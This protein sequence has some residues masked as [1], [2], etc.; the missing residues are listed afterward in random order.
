VAE[1]RALIIANDLYKHEGLRRLVAPTHD[2]EALERVLAHPQVG[3]FDVTV[4]RNRQSHEILLEIENFFNDRKPDDLLVLHFSGHGLKSPAGELYL[5]TSDTIP[6]RLNA[7]AVPAHFINRQ[8]AES[9][10]RRIVVFLDCCYG[11]AFDRGTLARSDDTVNVTDAFPASDESRLRAG[12]GR[13]RIVITASSAT[14][15]AFEDGHLADPGIRTPSVFTSALVQGLETGEADLGGDSLVDIDE[16]Y[17]YVHARVTAA[18]NRQTPGRSV[19]RQEG[20]VVIAWT[21]PARR[22]EA[23]EI[24][25]ELA[26]QSRDDSREV[27]LVAVRNLRRILLDEDRAYAVGALDVLRRL[28]TDDSGSVSTAAA[29]AIEEAQ[30]KAVPAQVDLGLLDPDGS[31]RTTI[32]RLVGSP[33]ARVFQATSTTRWLRVEQ[34]END[35]DDSVRITV[36]NEALPA[37]RGPLHGSINIVNLIGEFE[38]PVTVTMTGRSWSPLGIRG[39]AQAWVDSSKTLALLGA[40]LFAAALIINIPIMQASGVLGIGYYMIRFALLFT[41]I[42]L[43]TSPGTR[44]PAG[45]GVL[46]ATVGYFATDAVVT[47]HGSTGPR[48][49]LEFLAVIAFAGLLVL[50]LRPSPG[51]LRRLHLIPPTGPLSYIVLAAAA[52]QFILLFVA[53]PSGYG[54]IADNIGPIGALLGLAPT[55]LCVVTALTR[56]WDQPQRSFVAAA[57]AAYFGPE[58]YFLLGS[59]LLGPNFSYLGTAFYSSGEEHTWFVLAQAVAVLA[60]AAPTLLIL[61]STSKARTAPV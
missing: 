6:N 44:L 1:R 13:G 35:A 22:I 49:W 32:V 20:K 31:A 10:A 9:R 41:G 2:A 3:R 55:C 18:T 25:P 56:R 11:G 51:V 21:P 14:E 33:L 24:S 5:A 26:A 60:V 50:R 61:R 43:I 58:L 19:S 4:I 37:H 52:A 7:T 46:G 27:R 42:I 12:E 8:L 59:V 34:S 53:S 23:A 40:A 39:P 16:L 15:Y 45:L 57:V 54:S 29:T 30:L 47:L 28:A 38:V 17:E 48:A 36:E